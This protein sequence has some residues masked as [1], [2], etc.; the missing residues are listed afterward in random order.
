MQFRFKSIVFAGVRLYSRQKAVK[1]S[2]STKITKEILDKYVKVVN[3]SSSSFEIHVKPN[4]KKCSIEFED[5]KL[6]LKIASQPIEGRANKEV[7]ETLSD[8]LGLPKRSVC[9]YWL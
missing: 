2:S 6:N 4:S 9:I 8:L 7:C 5:D 1:M 3:P